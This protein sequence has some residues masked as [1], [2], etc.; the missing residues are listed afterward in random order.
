MIVSNPRVVQLDIHARDAVA[1]QRFYTEVFGWS[2]A[3]AGD[4]RE[5]GWL[6]AADGAMFGGIG[7]AE[8]SAESGISFFA[9]VDDPQA[10]LN[11]AGQLGGGIFWGPRAFPD[12]MILACLRDPEGNGIL[13]IRPGDNGEPY[14][15][16]SPVVADRWSW[17]IQS[18]HP[19]RLADFYTALFGW[20]IEA[21]NEWGWARVDT[22]PEGGPV[23]AIARADTPGVFFYVTVEELES[24]LERAQALGATA[25]V[26]PWEVDPATRIAVVLDPEGNRLGLMQSSHAPSIR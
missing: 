20:R 18:P 16:R 15:S 3:P 19:E 14:A 22:G 10:V 17:E 25:V 7:Q 9:Q 1:Q 26:A 6:F 4:P 12:G 8:E 5:Y 13:L 11:A 23:G 24:H 21:P 2:V